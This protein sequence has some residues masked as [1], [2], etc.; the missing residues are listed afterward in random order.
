MRPE[1]RCLVMDDEM[2]GYPSRITGD[3]DEAADADPGATPLEVSLEA[4]FNQFLQV[5]QIDDDVLRGARSRN[6]SVR[7][8][9]DHLMLD[10]SGQVIGIVETKTFSGDITVRGEAAQ[11]I[12]R[13]LPGK[14]AIRSGVPEPAQTRIVTAQRMLY[15]LIALI[16]ILVLRESTEL[17]A[18]D[19]S[20]LM[21]AIAIG[22]AAW[23][24]SDHL[25]I[26]PPDKKDSP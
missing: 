18:S 20:V 6:Q 22:G 10:L 25:K 23:M 24:V 2:A 19:Q 9:I 21:N 16:A 1:Y 12:A 4:L 14:V 11:V 3:A 8:T 5:I 15:V 13:A 26:E 17:S 7:A